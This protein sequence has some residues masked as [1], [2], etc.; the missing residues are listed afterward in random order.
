MEIVSRRGVGCKVEGGRIRGRPRPAAPLGG[1]PD[2]VIDWVRGLAGS[3]AWSRSLSGSA[4]RLFVIVRYEEKIEVAQAHPEWPG[5]PSCVDA[6][7]DS[8]IF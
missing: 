6:A 2:G 8:A 1:S 4:N 5:G 7:A 3:T